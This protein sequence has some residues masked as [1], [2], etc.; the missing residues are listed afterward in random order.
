MY[1]RWDTGGFDT[2]HDWTR[3]TVANETDHS[4]ANDD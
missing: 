1:G 3:C 2:M 4:F